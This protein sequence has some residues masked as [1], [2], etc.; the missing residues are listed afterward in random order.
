M[1]FRKGQARKK[2]DTVEG[3]IILGAG[4]TSAVELKDVVGRVKAILLTPKSEWPVIA[5]EPATVKEIYTNYVIILA[6]IPAVTGFVVASIIG[7]TIPFGGTFRVPIMS[8]LGGALV[9]YG[10]SLAGIFVVA[11]IIDALAPSFGGTKNQIQALKAAA[12]AY[13]AYWVASVAQ[14][15]PFLGTLI[16][17][18]GGIYSL[19]L[20]YLGLPTM[21]KSPR[22]RALPYTAVVVLGAIVIGFIM[23]WVASSMLGLPT[24]MNVEPDS[25]QTQFDRESPLGQ[26]EAYGKRMEEAGKKLESAQQSDDPQAQQQAF[27]ELFGAVL[28]GDGNVEAL[29]IDR[30]AS[31]APDEIDDMPQTDISSER[32]AMFGVQVS[33]TQATYS[34]GDSRFLKLEIIDFGGTAG[35]LSVAS[36]A[37]IEQE[38]RNANGYERSYKDDGRAVHERWDNE[39]GSGEF[40][41]IVGNRF[42]V[43]ATGQVASIDVLE[44]AVASVDLAELERIAP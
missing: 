33:Q 2:D 34:D 6:A 40:G 5:E 20:L 17:L 3:K 10:L 8:G 36:W 23:S 13:T 29:P 18:A 27:G 24:G 43:Q 32:N 41:V 44:N 39:R 1:G 37:G 16:A 26:L 19:Y 31:F 7:I 42:L 21:M 30:I 38:K 35:L 14:I 12:Y 25:A 4:M 28:G 22:E 15:L 9:S 11:L